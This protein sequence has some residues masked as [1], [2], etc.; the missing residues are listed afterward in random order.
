[1]QA[2]RRPLGFALA[3][4]L[5][6]G[7]WLVPQPGG[8]SIEG[9]HAAATFLAIVPLMA[10]GCLPD[11]VLALVLVAAWVLGGVATPKVAL[12]GFASGT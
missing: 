9:W 3:A 10:L 1:V 6:V 12:G 2:D 11:G 7:G 8:F 5:L 4:L